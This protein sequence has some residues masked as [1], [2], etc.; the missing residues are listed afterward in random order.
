[1]TVTVERLRLPA[2]ADEPGP[3]GEAFRQVAALVSRVRTRQL[4][5]PDVASPAAEQLGLLR[6]I[7]ERRSLTFAAR[8]AGRVVGRLCLFLPLLESLTMLEA[9]W[10]VDPDLPD[11]DLRAVAEALAATVDE[12]SR[13]ERRPWVLAEVPVREGGLPAASGVGSIDPTAPDAAALLAAGFTFQQAYR[14]QLL[15]LAA[16]R[17]LADRAADGYRIAAWVGPVPS[18]FR[19]DFCAL[20]SLMQSEVPSGGVEVEAAIWDDA[21]LTDYE[22]LLAGAGRTLLGA[23]AWDAAGEP[24]GYTELMVS[25]SPLARQGD[26]LVAPA[27]RGHGL[28]ERLKAANQEQLRALGHITQVVTDNAE[29]NAHMLA[30]N[31]RLGF[32][33]VH[34]EG[35]FQRRPG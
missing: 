34:R 27:H 21:R 5:T 6:D 35:L 19:A 2:S 10:H 4:G 7:G 32:R 16:A 24:A 20:A 23:L 22:A 3:D 11:A 8:L 12:A 25:G 13:A 9:G 28:G 33:S 15:D 29:E 18:A 31:E 17:P 14:Y 1:M 26:T 30:I